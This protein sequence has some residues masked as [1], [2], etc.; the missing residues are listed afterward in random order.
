MIILP[1]PGVAEFVLGGTF[2]LLL[3][4]LKLIFEVV[5]V[6]VVA[7]ADEEAISKLFGMQPLTITSLVRDE[8]ETKGEF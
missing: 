3:L 8:D 7:V 2:F 4:L 5:V 1:S 6:V